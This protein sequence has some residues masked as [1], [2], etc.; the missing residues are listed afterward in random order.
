MRKLI[1]LGAIALLGCSIDSTTQNELGI[2]KS[3]LNETGKVSY[4]SNHSLKQGEKIK[5]FTDSPFSL[6]SSS[7][8]PRLNPCDVS[9]LLQACESA[10]QAYNK[11]SC[12]HM[13]SYC[14][15]NINTDCSDYCD[16]SF[17][18]TQGVCSDYVEYGGDEVK[19]LANGAIFFECE[20]NFILNTLPNCDTAYGLCLVRSFHSVDT[21]DCEHDSECLNKCQEQ[22]TECLSSV[23]CSLDNVV[24]C[25]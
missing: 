16:C 11:A 12:E 6:T 18:N 14:E 19:K 24:S 15:Q 1:C 8:F 13:C 3:S 20:S 4:N 9:V 2:E 22:E 7:S 23:S 10:E 21:I 17:V 25:Q 5:Q